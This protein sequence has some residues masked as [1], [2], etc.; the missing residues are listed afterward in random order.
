[1]LHV[2]NISLTAIY[3]DIEPYMLFA[4]LQQLIRTHLSCY[5]ASFMKDLL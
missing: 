2:V 4:K 3:D 5:I 1:V